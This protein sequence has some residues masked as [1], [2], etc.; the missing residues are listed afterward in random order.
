METVADSLQAFPSAPTRVRAVRWRA[1]VSASLGGRGVEGAES[2]GAPQGGV[3]EV[4]VHLHTKLFC[5]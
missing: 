3:K 4:I 1:G 5:L 2:T